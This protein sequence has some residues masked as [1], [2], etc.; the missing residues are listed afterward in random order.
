MEL[1]LTNLQSI[2]S[3]SKQ[4]IANNSKY[5]FNL[6]KEF[7]VAINTYV[8]DYS[9]Y[10][11]PNYHDFLEIDYVLEGKGLL[12]IFNKQYQ[13]KKDDIIIICNDELHTF[14]KYKNENFTVSSLF[15]LPEIIYKPGGNEF[16]FDFLRPFFYRGYYF[17]P[18][19]YSSGS[20]V[21]I[22]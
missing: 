7:P 10:L 15:L 8:F 21:W 6:K 1:H 19:R 4:I 20:W 16:D 3:I 12:N 14:M 5:V 2:P 22:K 17:Q 9:F 13:F 11:T 18:E